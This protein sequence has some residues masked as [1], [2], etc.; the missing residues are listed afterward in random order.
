MNKSVQ[1]IV[2]FLGK[3]LSQPLPGHTA[4]LEM[5]PYRAQYITN[6]PADAR[7]SA[8]LINIHDVN[9]KPCILLIKRMAYDG[10]HSAQVSFPGGKRDETDFDNLHTALRENEEETGIVA[11]HVKILGQLTQ[12]YIPPS[13]TLVHVF[14]G[15]T[16]PTPVIVPHT[17]E[18]DYTF[19]LPVE[20]LMKHEILVTGDIT[21]STGLTLNDIPYFSYNNEKIW[22]ATCAILNELKHVLSEI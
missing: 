5:T 10:V 16:R 22:G 11:N 19:Y 15:Y 9:N 14:V 4:H 21:L 20:E 7:Q 8:V 13:R 6:V 2:D 12:I 17:R 1:E 18:V 3:R